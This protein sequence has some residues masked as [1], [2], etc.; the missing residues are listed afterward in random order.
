MDPEADIS[1][2][3]AMLGINRMSQSYGMPPEWKEKGIHPKRTLGSEH[4][5]GMD[6][7]FADG[8]AFFLSE[9]TS[10]EELREYLDITDD[11]VDW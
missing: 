7:A 2:E 8:S 4:P 5:G 10:E 9:I 3:D 6:A 1:M 11:G